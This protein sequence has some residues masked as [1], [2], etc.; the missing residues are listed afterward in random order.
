MT[1]FPLGPSIIVGVAGVFGSMAG[2]TP[3]IDE[4]EE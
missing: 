4:G 2:T 3:E 1:S